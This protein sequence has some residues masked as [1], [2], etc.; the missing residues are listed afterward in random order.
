MNL[1]R[2]PCTQMQEP[3]SSPMYK[4]DKIR[5][6]LYTTFTSISYDSP[7]TPFYILLHYNTMVHES[8]EGLKTT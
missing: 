3:S 6:N 5:F 4:I 2:S 8:W 7:M 1:P